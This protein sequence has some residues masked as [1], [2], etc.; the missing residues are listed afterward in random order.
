MKIFATSAAELEEQ[1]EEVVFETSENCAVNDSDFLNIRN[2]KYPNNSS[3]FSNKV[4]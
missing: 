1:E 4:C 3:D 2:V